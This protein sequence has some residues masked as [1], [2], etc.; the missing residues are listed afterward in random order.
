M[1]TKIA[2]MVGSVMAAFLAVGCASGMASQQL[3]DARASYNHAQA[4]P[5]A[6]LMPV[7]LHEAKVA[8][9]AAEQA[10]ADD[11]DSERAIGLSYVAGRKARLAQAQGNAAQSA[12]QAE[13]AKLELAAMTDRDLASTKLGLQS[14]RG[15]LVR[16][17]DALSMTA[18]QLGDEKKAREAAD[19]RARDAVDK[20]GVAAALS[21][22]EEP[23]GTV[24]LLPGSVMFASNKAELLPSAQTKLDAVAE[25]L[26]NQEDRKMVVEGHTDS[27]GTEA[28]NME[29][30][31]R[32]A[33]AVR[34]YLV[35]RGVKSEAIV[36]SGI[37]QAR[38]IGDNRSPEGRANNRRVEV[39]IQSI[40]KR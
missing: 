29:L 13:Q 2:P 21:I 16:T 24:I 39:V 14:A 19:K 10:S 32:R 31:Q 40:E 26:K 33:Q 4:A 17:K 5:G 8:L 18:V 15:E 7:P 38:P 36:A 28:S 27:Q 9:D 23:R 6:K 3:M 37:G 34:D 30:G 20:L 11:A 22:K 25:A 1:K 12:A 35:Q